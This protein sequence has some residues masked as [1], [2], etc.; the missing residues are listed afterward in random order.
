MNR[1]SRDPDMPQKNRNDT[2]YPLSESNALE[3]I[4]GSQRKFSDIFQINLFS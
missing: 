3:F 1:A 2:Y 4:N